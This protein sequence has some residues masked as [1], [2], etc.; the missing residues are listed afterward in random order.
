MFWYWRRCLKE[1][2]PLPGC[3]QMG[4]EFLM[5][6]RF[7]KNNLPLRGRYLGQVEYKF[8]CLMQ[9]NEHW[10][11][12]LKT[13]GLKNKKSK[14]LNIQSLDVVVF[15]KSNCE[16]TNSSSR[17]ANAREKGADLWVCMRSKQLKVLALFYSSNWYVDYFALLPKSA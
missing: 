2:P 9:I 10:V 1:S 15:S 14:T 16:K 4:L 5:K 6:S 8:A 13:K 7:C 17:I 12:S 3:L 11:F